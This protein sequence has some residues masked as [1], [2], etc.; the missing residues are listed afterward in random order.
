MHFDEVDVFGMQLLLV[1]LDELTHVFDL[2]Q[3]HFAFSV[4]V[5]DI[6]AFEGRA[7]RQIR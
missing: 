1:V 3:I 7:R 2:E 5:V 4:V 6:E